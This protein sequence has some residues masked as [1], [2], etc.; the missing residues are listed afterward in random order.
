MKKLASILV[1]AF[2]T[3]AVSAQSLIPIKY[4]VKVGTNISNIISTPN[5]GVTNIETSSQIGIS[6]GFY[7]EIALND[8]WFINPELMY[9]QKG[10]SFD[11]DYKHKWDSILTNDVNNLDEYTTKNSLNLAYIV[12]NPTVSYKASDKLA[13][14]F[15]PSVSFLISENYTYNEEIVGENSPL[16]AVEPIPGTY[17]SENLDIGLN[18]G[19]SYYI[20]ESFLVDA[21]VNTGFMKAGTVNKITSIE[22]HGNEKKEYIYD[23]KNK[24]VIFSI[25]YLF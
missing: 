7:M 19:F 2:F 14:N 1:L 17:I 20:T 21:K 3:I 15:G 16:N 11:Y 25:A 13:L 18:L 6:G 4:G 5:E 8:K 23:L 22:K 24:G 9:V 10:A 12:L